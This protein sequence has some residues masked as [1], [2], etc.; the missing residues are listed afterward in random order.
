MVNVETGK[1]RKILA[2]VV[3]AC[4]C[5]FA[6]AAPAYAFYYVHSNDY[7]VKEDV[8]G[9]MEILC[10]LDERATGGTAWTGLIFI[11]ANGTP[12]NC[13][14][15]MIKASDDYN[16]V[17]ALHNYDYAAIADVI[18]S[19]LEDGTWTCTV[20]NADTQSP[21]TQAEHDADNPG[22]SVSASELDTYVLQRY[23]NVEFTA[24]AA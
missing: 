3:A 6:I 11:P 8:N 19:G 4:L 22:T 7:D 17:E 18:G 12:A 16:G 24:Q 20:W 21:G 15:Q 10:T 9:A 14:E 1:N 23:D 13:L 2:V 5:V